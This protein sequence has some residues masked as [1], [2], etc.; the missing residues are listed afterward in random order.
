M[1]IMLIPPNGIKMFNFNLCGFKWFNIMFNNNEID[2][3]PYV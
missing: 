3:G 1:N 2:V